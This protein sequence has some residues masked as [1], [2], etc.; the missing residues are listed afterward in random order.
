MAASAKEL[1]LSELQRLMEAKKQRLSALLKRRSKLQ[2]DLAKV[3]EEISALEGRRRA[4]PSR[5]KARKGVKNGVKKKVVRRR[6]RNQQPLHAVVLEVLGKSKEGL[7]LKDLAA[8]I[9]ETGYKSGSSNFNN[10]I[11]Q[12][13]YKLLKSKTVEHDKEAHVYRVK[14]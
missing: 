2:A 14:K 12:T 1:S 4:A 3:E 13:L 6:R 5:S 10:V 11:Y 7:S 9:K 8:K